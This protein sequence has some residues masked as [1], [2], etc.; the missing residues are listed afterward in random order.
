MRR[1]PIA[2]TAD[3]AITAR[4]E[5]RAEAQNKP[6]MATKMRKISLSVAVSVMVTFVSMRF[7]FANK[8]R[9]LVTKEVIS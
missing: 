7:S 6:D 1:G 3:P 5:A 8:A 2:P 4:A 9:D